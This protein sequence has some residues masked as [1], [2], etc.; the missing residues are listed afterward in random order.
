MFDLNKV[1]Y[2]DVTLSKLLLAIVIILIG[3]L[4]VK[5]SSKYI[6]RLLKDRTDKDQTAVII[7]VFNY[8]IIAIIT[9][10]IL[11]LIGVDLS[12]LIVAGGIL[13]VA[14]GFAS[15]S[16]ISNLLSGIFLMIEHPI[17]MGDSVNIDGTEGI[18]DN[19]QIMSTTLR[20][21]DGLYVRIPNSKVFTSNIKNYD[22]NKVRRI[23]YKI[24]I[25]YQDDANKAISIIKELINKDELA[26]VRPKTKVFVDQL[27]DSSVDIQVWVWAPAQEW[28]TLR[29][30]LLWKIKTEL[31]ANNIEIPFPQ[32]VVWMA[33]TEE[34]EKE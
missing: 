16:I 4:F 21:F 11:P 5:I 22:T 26:L 28:V 18:V 27:G 7:R 23:T 32:R 15:Q 19:I 8:S 34:K 25:R 6:K 9:L 14:V 31:E 1:L 29:R 24:G 13:G 17:R 33:N 10:T 3:L 30:R 12:G 20:G 2:S